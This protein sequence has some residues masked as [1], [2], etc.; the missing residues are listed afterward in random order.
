MSA[1]PTPS[2]ITPEVIASI[3]KFQSE[4]LIL[5]HANH[6]LAQQ[7]IDARQNLAAMEAKC[8]K[9]HTQLKALRDEYEPTVGA[10]AS[11]EQIRRLE[12]KALDEYR[13]QI[14]ATG[15]SQ[16]KKNMGKMPRKERAT[17]SVEEKLEALKSACSKLRER[18]DTC[19][20]R[21]E[22]VPAYL[23]SLGKEISCQSVQSGLSWFA[24]PVGSFA[25]KGKGPN[26]GTTVNID[27][28]IERASD[29]EQELVGAAA[30]PSK[31][32]KK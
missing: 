29:L 7:L 23:E 19:D 20:F 18:A 27:A 11:D 12:S 4:V 28:W 14:S 5:A 24:P 21:K 8:E 30:K 22:F 2:P 3:E 31:A 13:H 6:E 1:K 26:G 15:K 10:F 9:Y 17:A 16:K 32:K 25:S